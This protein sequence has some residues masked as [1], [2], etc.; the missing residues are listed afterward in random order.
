MP[1]RVRV[2]DSKIVDTQRPRKGTDTLSRH[3]LQA[4]KRKKGKSTR[5]PANA[6][7]LR[8][9]VENQFSDA[10]RTSCTRFPASLL[11]APSPSTASLSCIPGRR[12]VH[13]VL[14]LPAHCPF[15]QA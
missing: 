9:K 11:S 6:R 15:A 7:F 12:S 5:L 4:Q 14:H 3:G 2:Q 13:K 10:F 8:K 1:V